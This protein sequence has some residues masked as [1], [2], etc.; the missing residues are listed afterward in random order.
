MGVGYSPRNDREPMDRLFD[1]EPDWRLPRQIL[2][3][4]EVRVSGKQSDDRPKALEA[5]NFYLAQAVGSGA[6]IDL[7]GYA[8]DFV[9]SIRVWD[10]RTYSFR[11]QGRDGD[12]KERYE[13]NLGTY[14]SEGQFRWQRSK[15]AA[16]PV[17]LIPSRE[18]ANSSFLRG[19][20]V[21]WRTI[22]VV[23]AMNS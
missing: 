2:L 6:D 20:G 3:D 1:I 19:V 22:R 8:F 16:I 21:E 4:H 5:I 12:C 17:W 11:P 13:M 7:S 18:C 14:D 23:T 9:R 15:P 10:V